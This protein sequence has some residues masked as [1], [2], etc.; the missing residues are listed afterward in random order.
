MKTVAPETI[1][2]MGIKNS[3]RTER[4]LLSDIEKIVSEINGKE[5]R[6][7]KIVLIRD[8]G[9]SFATRKRFVTTIEEMLTNYYSGFCSVPQE[10]R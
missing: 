8:F 10:L 2:E 9:K 4:Y 7:F 1:I 6:S 5:I 3:S